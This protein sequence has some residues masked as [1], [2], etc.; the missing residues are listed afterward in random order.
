MRM[1]YYL[2][3]ILRR[4]T[5]GSENGYLFNIMKII[6]GCGELKMFPLG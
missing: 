6:H 3:A 2:V 4:E 5:Q 1:L